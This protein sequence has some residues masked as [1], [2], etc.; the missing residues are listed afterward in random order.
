MMRH[1]R[2]QKV[3]LFLAIFPFSW[4]LYST[5]CPPRV[6]QLT[7]YNTE[8]HP[9]WSCLFC[10]WVEGTTMDV[11]KWFDFR[12]DECKDCMSVDFPVLISPPEI[13]Q[14][15]NSV[16]VL[17]LIAAG[18]E[19][20]YERDTV[21]QT[22]L[23]LAG[24]NIDYVFVVGTSTSRSYQ[25]KLIQESSRHKDILQNDFVD[26]YRNLT[27]KTL[28]GLK[29]AVKNC[30]QIEFVFKMDT[31]T[32]VNLPKMRSLIFGNQ[33]SKLKEVM[34]GHCHRTPCVNRI[35]F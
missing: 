20:R 5:L 21:R 26:S 30:P 6:L 24:E 14:P 31:D 7:E 13:C 4:I 15:N 27:I 19:Q 12:P 35:P 1:H 32:L 28:A 25:Q 34:F 2:L 23:T 22:W 16:D 8:N 18:I 3:C 17:I 29:F 9:S 11:L 33:K 10:G